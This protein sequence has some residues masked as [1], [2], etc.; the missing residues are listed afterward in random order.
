MDQMFQPRGL[1]RGNH[2]V[3]IAP[4]AFI[5]KKYPAIPCTM[6]SGFG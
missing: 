6:L 3:G 2:A 4:E 5:I 1:V